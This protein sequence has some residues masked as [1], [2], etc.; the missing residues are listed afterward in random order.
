MDINALIYKT[1]FYF[2]Y[3]FSRFFGKYNPHFQIIFYNTPKFVVTLMETQPYGAVFI[4]KMLAGKIYKNHRLWKFSIFTA[5]GN[6][7]PR[8]RN[9]ISKARTRCVRRPQKSLIFAGF[10][11]LIHILKK[12]YV[13]IKRNLPILIIII[14]WSRVLYIQ[15]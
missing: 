8:P 14:L 12:R 6:K 7:F 11:S 10:Q 4:H 5:V 3:F 1:L 13:A 9:V 2:S 15:F